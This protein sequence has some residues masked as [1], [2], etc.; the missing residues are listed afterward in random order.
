V[1]GTFSR[2]R[3]CRAHGVH[4]FE[5][6]LEAGLDDSIGDSGNTKFPDF[7]DLPFG[8]ITCRTSPGESSPDFSE[9][10]TWPRNASTPPLASTSA[11]V[12][13]SMPAVPALLSIDTRSPGAHQERRGIAEVGQ[14]TKTATAV[15]GCPTIQ[16][17]LHPPYCE[18]RESASY[19]AASVFT[20]A[21]PDITSSPSDDT[22][23][24]F[25][26]YAAPALGVLR[27]LRPPYETS[28]ALAR[29]RNPTSTARGIAA[30]RSAQ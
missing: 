14:V 16:L 19:A 29:V 18:V 25:R 30:T 28:P 7:P 9:S 21:S 10:L 8:I 23:P 11:A 15:F 5:H 2:G 6:R 26:G 20:G 27:R 13:W 4:G 22:L 17:S 3:R 12:A 1:I 24:L